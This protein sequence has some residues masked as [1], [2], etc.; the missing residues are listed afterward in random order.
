VIE[1]KLDERN[2][3]LATGFEQEKIATRGM[4]IQLIDIL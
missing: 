3:S 2:H 1:K 4:K